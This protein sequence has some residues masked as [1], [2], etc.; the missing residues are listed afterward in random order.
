MGEVCLDVKYCDFMDKL[1]LLNL[2]YNRIKPRLR[3]FLQKNIFLKKVQTKKLITSKIEVLN[4]IRTHVQQHVI[5]NSA[6]SHTGK[7]CSFVKQRQIY[8]I[9]LLQIC[10]I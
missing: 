5:N 4:N 7:N 2:N 1:S 6:I 9:W 3:F 10:E 8:S